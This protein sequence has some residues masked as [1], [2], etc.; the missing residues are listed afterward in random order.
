MA[1]ARSSQ[2]VEELRQAV[3]PMQGEAQDYDRL[4]E[5]CQD[6]SFIMMGEASHGSHEFYQARVDITKRLIQEQGLNAIAVEADWPAA[7]RINR[8]VRGLSE[9]ETV[10]QALGD[11]HRFPLWMWRNTVI[12]DFVQWLRDYNQGRSFESQVGFYGLDMYS[13]YDSIACVLDYLD[14]VDPEAAEQARAGY[15][16]LDDTQDEQ[17]YGFG[18]MLGNRPSCEDEALQQLM[19]LSENAL[20]YVKRN[21]M[22]AQDEQFQAEQNARLVR[23]AER[24]Y[25]T[26]FTGRVSTWNL[27]DRHMS[28]TLEA[29]WQHLNRRNSSQT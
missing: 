16:C 1:L 18:V 10:E 20:E 29:L 8:Y 14:E 23:S 2:P 15:S 7:Y 19:Q 21:G 13:M 24:Y 17:A 3:I 9:D 28:D 12:H 6:R 22:L 26:M 4:L 27:R 11:F 25:R 5:L